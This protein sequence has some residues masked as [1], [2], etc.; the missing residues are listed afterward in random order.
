VIRISVVVPARNEERLIGACLDSLLRQDYPGSI[1]IIV[2]DNDSSD[3]TAE[4]ARRAGVRVVHEPRAGYTMALAAGFRAADGDVVATT[5][6][7]TEV[8]SDW[9]SWLVREYELHPEVVAVGGAIRFRDPN[10]R[11]WLFTRLLLPLVIRVDAANPAGAHLWGANFSVR[12]EVF[13]QAGGW[14]TDFNL[15]ADTELSERLRRF[16]RVVLLRDLSVSTS[17]RRWN[18]SLFSGIFLYA[19]NFAWFQIARRPLW[20]AFPEIREAEAVPR[21]R[22]VPAWVTGRAGAM[23]A[24]A[25]VLIGVGGYD[26][27]APWSNA[28]GRTYWEAATHRRVVALTFDDGPNGPSTSQVLDILKREHVHAT[29]FLIGENV[30]LYPALAARI[31]R[32]GHAVGNHSDTHP[33]GFALEP[34]PVLRA[35]LERAEETIHAATGIY[36]ILFRPPQGIR[37]PWLMRVLE[38]DSLV[39]VTWDDAP[40]DWLHYS[41]RHLVASA[42]HSARPGAIILLHDGLNLEHPADRHATV[43]AL[44]EIIHRLRAEGYEFV[45]VPELLG[46]R[47]ELTH[48]F[49]LARGETSPD[50]SPHARGR[51]GI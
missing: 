18:R 5:D 46:C 16:G 37:S 25:A 40:G 44:P 12:R 2:V 27:F 23:A 48:P 35:Q 6:A 34:S 10:R 38:Q 29:F 31:V 24:V 51:A 22:P 20:R 1:Q 19:S 11:G 21:A 3:R 42:V 14:N 39:T 45:T 33:P 4:L 49:T 41:A 9:I 50:D 28:F 26:T 7:D 43:A 36:P 15:Q 47:P 32:E 8:P 17:C 30:R 13:E